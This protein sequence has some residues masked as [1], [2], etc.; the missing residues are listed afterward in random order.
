MVVL[1]EK[2]PNIR[3]SR[4]NDDQ[5]GRQQRSVHKG[6]ADLLRWNKFRFSAGRD[7]ECKT[8]FDKLVRLAALCRGKIREQKNGEKLKEQN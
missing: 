8:A 4:W 2:I 6:H 5:T 1:D 3:N 7:S